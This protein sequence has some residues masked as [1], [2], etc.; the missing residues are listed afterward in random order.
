MPEQNLKKT[1]ED[2]AGAVGDL[3][4]RY[5]EREAIQLIRALGDCDSFIAPGLNYR[6]TEQ[7]EKARRE[8]HAACTNV[9]SAIR[10]AIGFPA[11][12]NHQQRVVRLVREMLTARQAL[13]DAFGWDCAPSAPIP[14][15][16]V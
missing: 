12:A 13:L 5:N 8:F 16:R 14:D 2:V 7:Q 3:A 9:S 6:H 15:A 10:Q 11:E 4:Q 1:I